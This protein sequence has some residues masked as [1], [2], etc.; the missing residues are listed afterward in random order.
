MPPSEEPI[1]AN[2]VELRLGEV[3]LCPGPMGRKFSGN[4]DVAS[5]NPLLHDGATNATKSRRLE[6]EV[7]PP[8]RTRELG[9][10]LDGSLATL[11]F[12]EFAF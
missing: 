9:A 5:R 10:E 4:C 12:R 3:R 2:F 8:C 7:V 6:S 11:N 1:G